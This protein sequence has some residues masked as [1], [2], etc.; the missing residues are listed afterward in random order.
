MT[1]VYTTQQLSL[2]IPQERIKCHFDLELIPES[3]NNFS[4]LLKRFFMFLKA[5]ERLLK[6]IVLAGFDQNQAQQ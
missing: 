5:A 1:L 4:Y 6:Y 2:L 3:S